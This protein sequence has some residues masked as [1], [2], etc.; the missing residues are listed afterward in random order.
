M[1]SSAINRTAKILVALV[2]IVIISVAGF[3]YFV[4]VPKRTSSTTSITTTSSTHI[5]SSISL[6]QETSSTAV[7]TIT[8]SSSSKTSSSSGLVAGIGIVNSLPQGANYPLGSYYPT[9]PRFERFRVV[10]GNQWTSTQYTANQILTMISQLKPNVLERMTTDAIDAT[11]QLPVCSGCAPMDYLQFLNNATAD[12][13]C[14]IIP[15]LNINTSFWESGEFLSTAKEIL[16]TAVNPQFTI[17]SVDNWGTFCQENNCSCSM[18]Q[19][20]FQPLYQM[21]WKGVGVLNAASPYYGTC[22]WSTYAAFDANGNTWAV[23]QN[24]LSSIQNDKTQQKILL[25]DPDFPGQAQKWLAS[26]N[27]TCDSQIGPIQQVIAQQA[28]QGYTY[29]YPIEQTFWDANQIKTSSSGTYGG[30]TLYQIFQNWM[31]TY[32]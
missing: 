7:S 32:N 11:L 24:L 6:S 4:N 30:Q 26:C 17:L 2:V 16:Q 29:V 25:Y 15:R 28:S 10:Q 14:Y 1:S 8:T 18:D 21:G 22:G 5:S 13:G 12:C 9:G 27:P 31:N 3:V 23:N 19:Q 20:I